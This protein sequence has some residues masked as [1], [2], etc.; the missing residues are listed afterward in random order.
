M[1]GACPTSRSSGT[2]KLTDCS[3]NRAAEVEGIR[4]STDAV[5]RQE[6]LTRRHAI[7]VWLPR[8]VLP[9]PRRW[10]RG[11]GPAL[12]VLLPGRAAGPGPY[13][14]TCGQETRRGARR[15]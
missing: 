9:P 14:R 5:G 2:R 1:L 10:Q 15:G 13:H 7:L 12:L 11:R 3:Y 6:E 4:P 8:P